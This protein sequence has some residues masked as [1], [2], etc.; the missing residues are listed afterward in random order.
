MYCICKPLTPQRGVGGGVQQPP[1]TAHHHVG[2]GVQQPPHSTPHT[3]HHHTLL[4]RPV[5][6]K[7]LWWKRW[8][9]WVGE[10]GRN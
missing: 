1:H 8:Q 3:A 5:A 9:V 10:R 7:V 4:L 6:E 2:G